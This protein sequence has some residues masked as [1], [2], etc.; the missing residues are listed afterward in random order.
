[1]SFIGNEAQ[2]GGAIFV[3]DID[4]VSFLYLNLRISA[5]SFDQNCGNVTLNNSAQIY[6]DWIDWFVGKD[7]IARYNYLKY[8]HFGQRGVRYVG[9]CF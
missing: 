3:T 4:Y 6:G 2:R 7:G 1:M 5:L 8:L 9:Y